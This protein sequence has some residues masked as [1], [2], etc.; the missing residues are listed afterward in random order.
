M[1]KIES[2]RHRIGNDMSIGIKKKFSRSIHCIEL[3]AKRFVLSITSKSTGPPS[4]HPHTFVYHHFFF[5][6][7]S[8]PWSIL[9]KVAK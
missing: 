4:Y 7:L 5:H 6:L 2:T 9:E 3:H 8:G 1:T